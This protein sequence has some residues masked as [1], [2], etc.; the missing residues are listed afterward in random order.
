[1]SKPAGSTSSANAYIFQP[2]ALAISYLNFWIQCSSLV[3]FSILKTGQC[4]TLSTTHTKSETL[5]SCHKWLEDSTP[6]NLKNK[7]EIVKTTGGENILG[8]NNLKFTCIQVFCLIYYNVY[9]YIYTH[10]IFGAKGIFY[11]FIVFS[12][13]PWCLGL[14]K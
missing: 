10:T 13:S 12:H 8:A 9:I 3:P 11:T 2:T 6:A 7:H 5:W 4:P 14:V 1:M